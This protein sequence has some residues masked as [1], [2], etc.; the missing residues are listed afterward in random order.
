MAT[1]AEED[2]TCSTCL[3]VKKDPVTLQCKHSFCRACLEKWW[4]EEKGQQTC[5]LCRKKCHSMDDLFNFSQPSVQSEAICK[6]H[7]E[8]MELFCLDH[9]E[10]LCD[11]CKD[12][13]IHSGHKFCPLDEAAK[14][15]GEKLQEALQN[16]KEKLKDYIEIRDNCKDQSG[17]IKFQ[18]EQT[19]S[20]IKKNFEE[21][22]RFLHDEEGA[23]LSALG[24]EEQK[25]NQMINE[26]I[27]ALN[28]YIATLSEN[29]RTTEEELTSTPFYF[30]KNHLVAMNRI[31]QLPE[32]PKLHRG[33]LLD[34][35]KHVGNLKF[36]VWERM[37]DTVSYS[38][39]ILD[40][41]TACPALR[42]S[43]DLTR[44]SVK[45]GEQQYQKNPEKLKY[46][47]TVLG[48]DLDRGTQIW[49]VESCVNNERKGLSSCGETSN[50]WSDDGATEE[51]TG[52]RAGGSR[53]E[54]A[55]VL[56]GSNQDG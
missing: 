6:L 27:E 26:N 22:H 16:V 36:N 25:K 33:T 21:L 7:K 40:P 11:I 44:L 32:K 17:Y 9:H 39:V 51:K 50:V 18:K 10:S 54:D 2:L 23:R 14:N 15:H 43:E 31:Q 19:E 37:A 13:E 12:A 24:K 49:D 34:E 29:I 8:K 55:E 52:G 45:V 4:N 46:R 3:E 1:N 30:M 28:R 35:A 47:N 5:P 53:D 20:K 48:S 56:Y 42:L 41:K 38:P